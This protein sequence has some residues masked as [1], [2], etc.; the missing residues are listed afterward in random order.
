M[1]VRVACIVFKT[2]RDLSAFAEACLRFTPEITIRPEQAVFLEIGKSKSLYS[3]TTFLM[4]IQVLLRR[5]GKE[6]VQD[7]RVAIENDA[8]S[9]LISARYEVS[10][11][12]EALAS[13]DLTSLHDFADPFLLSLKNRPE[14]DKMI[15]TLR[16]LS[17]HQ[18]DQFLKIPASELPSRFGPWSLYVR[19]QVEHR[20]DLAWPKWSPRE[21]IEETLELAHD[22]YCHWLEPLLFHCK[23]VLDRLYSRLRGRALRCARLRIELK[24]ESYSTVREPLRAFDFDFMM[25]QGSTRRTLPILHERLERELASKPLES[26]VRSLRIE[27]KETT[28]GYQRQQH[29]FHKRDEIEEAYASIAAQLSESVGKAHVFRAVIRE[30]RFPEKSWKK[31]E[32][33]KEAHAD[34]TRVLAK[35][36]SRLLS[37]PQAITVDREKIQFKKK[38]YTIESWSCVESLSGEWLE[39]PNFQAQFRKYYEVGIREGPPLWIFEDEHRQYFLHGWFE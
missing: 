3:E 11:P 37:T 38:T 13:L 8:V 9:A 30:E 19:S 18:V 2:P 1:K 29:L 28:P 23:T 22:D 31:R 6:W 26:A 10:N 4:R 39:S 34:V 24:L 33:D 32:H 7:A 35:R 15:K 16:Q 12:M 17:L 5:F 14:L 36:P 25:P 27:M 20:L 21:V